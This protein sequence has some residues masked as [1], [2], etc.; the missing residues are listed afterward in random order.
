MERRLHL[1]KRANRLAEIAPSDE[2][3]DTKQVAK[4]LEV[5]EVWLANG[6]SI[7]YGPPFEKVFGNRVAYRPA[8][9]V[10]WLKQRVK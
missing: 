5:S 3:L 10:A 4:W 2:M 7:G 9:V 1:D 8:D 6:R